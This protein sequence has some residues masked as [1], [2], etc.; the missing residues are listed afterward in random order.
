MSQVS[1][2][3][4]DLPSLLAEYGRLA[5]QLS[6]SDAQAV[7]KIRDRLHQLDELIEAYVAAL[8]TQRV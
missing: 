7:E 3:Q 6:S 8:P 4:V 1:S 5:V 2:I